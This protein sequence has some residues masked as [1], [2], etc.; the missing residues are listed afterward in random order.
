MR[1]AVVGGTFVL[2]GAVFFDRLAP[3]YLSRTIAEDLGVPASLEGTLPL[4]IGLGWAVSVALANLL[5]GRLSNRHRAIVAALGAAAFDAVS[6]LT[7]TWLVFVVL[8]GV[9]GVLAGS[10]AQPVTALVFAVSPSG[11][12]GLDMGIVQSS[13]RVGGSLVSPAVVTA[14]AATAGWR[15]A[16]L[17]SAGVLLVSAALLALLVPA[18]T[19]PTSRTRRRPADPLE[20]QPGGRRNIVLST[21]GSVVLVGWL[22]IVSQGGVPLLEG[23]LE[24]STAGA[25]RVLSAFGVGAAVAALIVPI[26]SDRV[27]RARALFLAAVT[28]LVAGGTISILSG[29]GSGT[30]L[31]AVVLVLL[32]GVAMGG[33]P[34]VI[35]LIPAEAVARG[36]V[37][38]ALTAPIVAAEIV[39]GALLPLGAFALASVV[40][41]PIVIGLSS[42]LLL[43]LAV[44]SRWLCPP[45]DARIG[46]QGPTGSPT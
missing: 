2:Y 1:R 18:E 31:A 27:G 38:R 10:S 29:E 20:L 37:G 26:A 3:L 25:G 22:M 41:L 13:T 24:V 30:V 19:E 4:A 40:G 43:A 5:S 14:V 35:A 28:G 11:R 39:G 46:D 44:S 9:A 32:A 34:L 45:P 12:R 6:A 7:G 33:L 15:P 16:L 23:W 17:V 8:R 21:F 36:D 42:A